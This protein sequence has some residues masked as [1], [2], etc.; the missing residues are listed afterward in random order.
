[1]GAHFGK[2][3]RGVV[4]ARQGGALFTQSGEQAPW[5]LGVTLA[6]L[7]VPPLFARKLGHS[8]PIAASRDVRVVAVGFF[9]ALPLFLWACA[10]VRN[11]YIGITRYYIPLLPLAVFVAYAFAVADR[12]RESKMQGL[13]RMT[14]LGYLTGYLCMAA[15]G[16]VLLVLPG[17]RSSQRRA[18]LAGT[19]KLHP[20][21][22]TKVIYEFSASR[23]YH[24]LIS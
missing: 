4:D 6:L 24:S 7:V 16:V 23:R 22:S 20:W 17:E 19:F 21:P 18:K 12:K 8:G 1:M 13:L 14:S 2:L 3:R 15:V 5:L 9:V 11:V 10:I